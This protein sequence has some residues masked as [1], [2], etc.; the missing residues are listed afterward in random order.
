MNVEDFY[1]SMCEVTENDKI[2]LLTTEID[3]IEINKDDKARHFTKIENVFRYLNP[4]V[5]GKKLENE[6]LNVE[7]IPDDFDDALNSFEE[8]SFE[9]YKINTDNKE[10]FFLP[11]NL[12]TT[13]KNVLWNN[14]SKKVPEILEQYIPQKIRSTI[15]FIKVDSKQVKYDDRSKNSMSLFK[16]FQSEETELNLED[17]VRK[18]D[19]I[20]TILK[21]NF[22]ESFEY[23][24]IGSINN[25]YGLLEKKDKSNYPAP[26]TYHYDFWMT[27][28]SDK[29]N[30]LSLFEK[31]SFGSPIIEERNEN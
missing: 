18:I 30:F 23:Y 25:C 2:V 22:I 21:P 24:F 1:V 27:K 3:K 29:N 19:Y 7:D 5:D 17:T 4:K 13:L 20:K 6:H 26:L 8:N 16:I 12:E 31:K 9:P 28:D 14:Q 11:S 10:V 15:D